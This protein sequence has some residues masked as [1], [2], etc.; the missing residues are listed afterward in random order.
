MVLFWWAVG[1][2][3]MWERKPPVGC[4]GWS[5][6]WWWGR[7]RPPAKRSGVSQPV[8]GQNREIFLVVVGDRC[9]ALPSHVASQV[10]SGE[11]TGGEEM[12]GGERPT[13]LTI[14]Q[15]RFCHKSTNV[16]P[17]RRGACTRQGRTQT[18][19]LL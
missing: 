1:L 7:G 13:H 5:R 14:M 12:A 19:R 3:G 2:C 18:N 10:R 8:T 16:R 6:K 4:V 15:L 9:H 17:P 11:M